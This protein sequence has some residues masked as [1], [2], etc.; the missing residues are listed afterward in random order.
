LRGWSEEAGFIGSPGGVRA[1]PGQRENWSRTVRNDEKPF[2]AESS[3]PGWFRA[4]ANHSYP[5]RYM[6]ATVRQHGLESP[7]GFVK[8]SPHQKRRKADKEVPVRGGEQA[9]ARPENPSKT[10][11]MSERNT[12]GL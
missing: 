11:A 3:N 4:W 12:A 5:E 1:L 6:V 7:G 9:E 10:S 2:R 8:N